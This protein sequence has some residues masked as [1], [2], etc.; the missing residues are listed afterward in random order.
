M[1]LM[2][3]CSFSQKLCPL[4]F[5]NTHIDSLNI[6]DL[7]DT[8]YK[9]NILRFTNNTFDTLN[10]YIEELHLTKVENI[11]LD[12]NFINPSV[13][14]NLSRIYVWGYVSSV[15]T[16]FFE[17]LESLSQINFKSTHFRKL[18]HRKGIEWIRATNRRL[19][20]NVHNETD[21][22]R[23]FDKSRFLTL[24]CE[25]DLQ[26]EPIAHVFPDAD[27]CIYRH[28]PFRQLVFLLQ[29]C[30]QKD[31]LNKI[32]KLNPRLTCTYLWINRYLH[33]VKNRY[34]KD[35]IPMLNFLMLIESDSYK[36]MNR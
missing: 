13:F 35:S 11:P 22:M 4:V 2:I 17:S 19:N 23:N 32:K 30:T 26:E 28:Y 7:V 27:F 3:S 33:L 8:F 10:S 6:N 18:I 21:F 14:R 31:L 24:S 9:T 29:Y 1:L 15:S 20:L 36:S 25:N 34:R 5:A 12:L 16:D